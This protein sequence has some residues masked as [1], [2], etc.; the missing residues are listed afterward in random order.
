MKSRCVPCC[1]VDTSKTEMLRNF[2]IPTAFLLHGVLGA[3]VGVDSGHYINT[4]VP[5]AIQSGPDKYGSTYAASASYSATD[6]AVMFT[7]TTWGRFFESPEQMRDEDFDQY[8]NVRVLKLFPGVSWRR[9]LC[10]VVTTNSSNI[11]A[12]QAK[13]EMGCFG[14]VDNV[15]RRRRP[16]KHVTRFI[17]PPKRSMYWLLV[18][19]R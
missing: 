2:I 12:H 8:G 4:Y 16:T 1:T 9:P 19:P 7:G 10:Q 18:T 15:S 6:N 17:T 11:M 5:S 14:P 13:D 3:V